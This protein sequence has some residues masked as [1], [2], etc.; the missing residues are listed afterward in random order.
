MSASYAKTSALSNASTPATLS[1][2]L[3]SALPYLLTAAGGA[4]LGYAYSQYNGSK[5]RSPKPSAAAHS[6]PPSAITFLDTT[7]DTPPYPYPS[8]DPL[9]PEWFREHGHAMIDWC[10]NYRHALHTDSRVTR[11]TSGRVQLPVVTQQKPGW[12]L[13][14]LPQ[15]AP[16]QP[17][18]IQDV[19]KDVETLIVPVTYSSSAHTYIYTHTRTHH[20]MHS[21][22]LFS[23]SP[24]M[25]DHLYAC[26]HV[27][28]CVAQGLTHWQSPHFYAWFK[29]Y[30]SFPSYLADI[31][32]D[33]FSTIG[34]SWISSPAGL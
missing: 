13:R 33:A 15:Q 22:S 10:T 20:H 6:T 1:S 17:E 28:A 2:S 19:M 18:S 23:T 24:P 11:D 27:C 32:I 31:L 7:T 16:E 8:S 3:L 5:S 21:H 12:L 14:A 4:V 29:N 34:F 25:P 26:V 9:H 30:S